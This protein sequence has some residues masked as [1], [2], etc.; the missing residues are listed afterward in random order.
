MIFDHLSQV[1]IFL[2]SLLEI[3]QQKPS[4]FLSAAKSKD[5]P[6]VQYKSRFLAT[7]RLRSGIG[8]FVGR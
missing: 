5:R 8:V 3:M 7:P 6:L 4:P 2:P 1:C